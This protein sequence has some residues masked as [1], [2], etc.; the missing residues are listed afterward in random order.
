MKCVNCGSEKFHEEN[1]SFMGSVL[2]CDSCGCRTAYGASGIPPVKHP[3]PPPPEE[4]AREAK[5]KVE[6]NKREGKDEI[7]NPKNPER[8]QQ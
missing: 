2:V 5:A 1:S 6:K 4:I 8:N 3:A 7:G